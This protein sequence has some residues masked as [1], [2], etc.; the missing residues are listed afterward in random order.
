MT[1]TACEAIAPPTGWS[2]VSVGGKT[3]SVFVPPRQAVPPAAILYLH[4][5]AEITLRDN[6]VYTP[7][8]EQAG[9]VCVCP[10]G[11]KSWWVDRI[12]PEY[13]PVRTPHRYL[14]DD[15]LPWMRSVFGLGDRRIALVGV[16]MGGQAVLRLAYQRSNEFPI[17]T[18][19]APAIEY[20]I[21]H[22]RGL[23]LDAIYP[24]AEAA[25][26]DSALL[27]V[28]GAARPRHQLIVCDPTD[29]EWLP[30]AE[31]FIDKLRSAGIPFEADLTTSAGGHTW[32]YFN[33]IAPQVV[34][35]VTSALDQESR[36]LPIH[37]G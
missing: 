16:S 32:D 21:W 11:G 31:K 17:V 28:Q 3:V 4:G 9:L 20:H 34:T 13:D 26:Q 5:H 25:R 29:E 18:A 36:R 37:A 15:V 10:P 30:S 27:A 6:P 7:L 35:F 19:I 1:E 2:D 8:M 24:T 14:L 22:G 33:H 23:P 12:S